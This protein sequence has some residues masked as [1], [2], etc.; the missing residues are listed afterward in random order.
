[1]HIFTVLLIILGVVFADNTVTPTPAPP[2][3]NLT[4]LIVMCVVAGIFMIC[5]VVFGVYVLC[6]KLCKYDEIV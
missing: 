3:N 1:M 2:N 4:M 6:S 5:G